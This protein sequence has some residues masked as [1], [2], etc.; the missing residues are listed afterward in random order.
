MV[1][2]GPDKEGRNRGTVV[3]E[4]WRRIDS[5]TYREEYKMRKKEI[6]REGYWNRTEIGGARSTEEPKGK[7]NC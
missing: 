2:V 6:G 5:S 1:H 3:A 7:C 4:D